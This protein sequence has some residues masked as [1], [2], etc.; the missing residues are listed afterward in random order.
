MAFTKR[1]TG[2]VREEKNVACYIFNTGSFMDKK[3]TKE[4][5]PVS[6]THLDVYKRQFQDSATELCAARCT[7]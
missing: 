3:V 7:I 2:F 1:V 5:T 6:Y 4:M